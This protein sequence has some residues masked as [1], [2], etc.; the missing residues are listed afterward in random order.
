MHARALAA[1]G[2]STATAASPALGS[3]AAA[4]LR[5]SGS[6]FGV[7]ATSD[8]HWAFVAVAGPRAPAVDVL[9]LGGSGAPTLVRSIPVPG[10]P[11]GETL[12]PDGKYLLAAGGDGVAVVSVARAESGAGGAVLGTLSAPAGT[13]GAGGAIEVAASPDGRFAFLTLEDSQRRRC[14]TSARRCHAASGPRIT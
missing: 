7:A 6:P 2:C 4:M 8:G 9:R 5:V 14:S 11:L 3:V 13:G 12:T 10:M 1:P